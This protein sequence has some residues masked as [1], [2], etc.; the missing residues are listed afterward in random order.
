M[1]KINVVA[2]QIGHIPTSITSNIDAKKI[3]DLLINGTSE[4]I[5]KLNRNFIV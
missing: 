3:N 5:M 1:R 2:I 4:Q